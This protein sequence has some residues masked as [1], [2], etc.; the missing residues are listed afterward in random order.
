MRILLANPNTSQS[1][2]DA[3]AAAARAV[4]GPGV[5]IKPVTATFG[6]RIIASRAEAAVA[7][8]AVLDLLA[9]EADGCDGVIIGA[10]LDSG[11]TAARELLRIPVVGLT[12]AALHVACLTGPRFGVVTGA[13]QGAVN[14]RELIA[15]Y[16]LLGRLAGLRWFDRDSATILREPQAAAR[17]I[18]PM[19]QA[20]VRGDLAD[21]VV[22]T[23]AVMAG[24][25]ALVQGEVPVPVLEGVSCAVALVEALVR[26][27]VPR[28]AGV[29]PR[30]VVALS[31]ALTR[32]ING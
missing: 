10:S 27:T 13:A 15:G 24:M 16:G 2:T 29:G 7:E 6:A 25:P 12:E 30:E 5:E 23:G 14:A 1:V 21:V 19:V 28:V 9:Q 22:L 18:V 20:L 32:R 26:L 3:M 11:L 31:A 8:H 4:A 17:A